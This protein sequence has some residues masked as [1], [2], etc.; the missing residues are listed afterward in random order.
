MDCFSE[1]GEWILDLC[2]GEG[3]TATWMAGTL[4]VRVTGIDIVPAAIETAK[5]KAAAAGVGDKATFVRG[6]I[7]DMTFDNDSFGE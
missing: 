3:F 2:C 7:F 6:N 1:S 5:T 4:G